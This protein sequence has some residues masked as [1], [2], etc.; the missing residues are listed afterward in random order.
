MAA[1]ARVHFRNESVE[2]V[3]ARQ[4]NL[5]RADGG[6]FQSYCGVNVNYTGFNCDVQKVPK[7]RNCVVVVRRRRGFAKCLLF[8]ISLC[9]L[10]D[11]YFI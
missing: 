7:E 8:A 5:F 3:G 6:A 9:D 2:F 10:T 1:T 4:R 11:L